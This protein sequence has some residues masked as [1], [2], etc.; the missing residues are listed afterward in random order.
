MPSSSLVVRKSPVDSVASDPRVPSPSR[1]FIVT[2]RTGT[3]GFTPARLEW[4]RSPAVD[5]TK[6]QNDAD[7][8]TGSPSSGS[9]HSPS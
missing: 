6:A 1:T 2:T 7:S 4:G 5:T 3:G 8:F 9:G